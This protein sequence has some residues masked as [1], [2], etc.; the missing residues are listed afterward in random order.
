MKKKSYASLGF[1]LILLL[2][3]TTSA[4]AENL[5]IV[6]FYYSDTCGSCKPAIA[7]IDEITEYYAENFTGSVIINK[8]E[9]GANATNRAEM[10]NRGLIYPSAIINNETKIPKAN[11][12]YN[13]L[14]E[15]IDAYI[16][17]LNIQKAFD[18]N[19]VSVPLIGPV[20]LTRLSLPVLT[21]VLA[22]LD[23]FNPCAF[24]ILIFLLTLLV[25]LQS[26]RRM[27]LVG[28][29]FIFFSG[30]FYFLFMF[31]M[32]NTLLITKS[33]VSMIS[34]AVGIVAVCIGLLNIKDFFFQKKGP[35]LSIPDEKRSLTFKKIR[36]L[37]K[38]PSLLTMLGATIFLAISV[39]FYELL[40]TLGLPMIYSA[41]L[42]EEN[43]P[44]T[45]YYTYLLFY[46]VVY[47]IPLL[48]IL[49]LF[50]FTL[51]KMKLTERQGK[52]LK[53]VSGIMIFSFGAI[54]LIDYTLLENMITPLALL[55][56][57]IILTFVISFL[58]EKYKH[59][60]EGQS[61]QSDDQ[62]I[63]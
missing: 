8:K 11:L 20:D 48:I 17:N 25:Y 13:E 26:K 23:S 22:A 18:E 27:L 36:K 58:W 21:I 37:V 45:G 33:F 38:S 9:V 2:L 28:G 63:K 31:V 29:I 47:V 19:I 51:G 3:T 55:G 35:S 43:L 39:N 12:T 44:L 42:A 56:L 41:R 61:S 30:L 49:L 62:A 46:N 57:S 54:F 40:C 4:L 60:K 53:L 7:V 6:D 14:T 34:V 52:K 10:R 15:I 5:V 59:K 1:F 24:F 16:A 32:F 50:T